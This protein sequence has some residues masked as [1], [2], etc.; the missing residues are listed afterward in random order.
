MG[1]RALGVFG[2]L[3]R[4]LQ[5]LLTSWPHSCAYSLLC[6]A[7]LQELQQGYLSQKSA[8]LP[9]HGPFLK[10]QLVL[11]QSVL[12]STILGCY[13]QFSPVISNSPCLAPQPSSYW[14][15]ARTHLPLIFWV[16]TSL[17][18]M[19][20]PK[21]NTCNLILMYKTVSS[22]CDNWRHLKAKPDISVLAQQDLEDLGTKVMER[23]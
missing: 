3:D 7:H 15:L 20:T 18:I 23:K 6:C 4:L 2:C 16:S 1:Q 8:A 22:T 11:P 19:L 14:C 12:I 5:S 9:L 10:S 13:Q 21:G 17:S